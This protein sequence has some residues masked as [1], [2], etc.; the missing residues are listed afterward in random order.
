MTS[1][2]TSLK[3]VEEPTLMMTRRQELM[4]EIAIEIKGMEVRVST[5]LKYRHPGR[6]RS[7]AND[8]VILE[9]PAKAAMMA[10]KE[11]VVTMLV[12]TVAPAFDAVA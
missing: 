6:P 10:Q 11:R 9:E 12:M 2:T 8:Q 5:L 1:D 7:R 3:A 4:V